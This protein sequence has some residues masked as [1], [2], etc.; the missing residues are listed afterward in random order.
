MFGCLS[1]LF[2]IFAAGP[3]SPLQEQKQNLKKAYGKIPKMQRQKTVKTL[4]AKVD[5]RSDVEN[6]MI[7]MAGILNFG[8]N[9]L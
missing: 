4:K 5:K 9:G 6:L 8:S 7:S 2:A 3:M 1:H